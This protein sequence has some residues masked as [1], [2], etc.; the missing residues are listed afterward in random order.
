MYLGL[1]MSLVLLSIDQ[2]LFYS[3]KQQYVV[4]P[5]IVQADKLLFRLNHL[6]L[7]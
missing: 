4:W 1:T 7:I 2:A 3:E 5:P 6:Q